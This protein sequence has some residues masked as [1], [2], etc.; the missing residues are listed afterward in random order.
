MPALS[1]KEGTHVV[2]WE[3]NQKSNKDGSKILQ[4]RNCRQGRNIF[5]SEYLILK[6]NTFVTT[7][8]ACK[9]ECNDFNAKLPP[10]NTSWNVLQ[11]YLTY[12][13]DS[14]SPSTW[15]LSEWFVRTWES[16]SL[17]HTPSFLYLYVIQLKLFPWSCWS[18]VWDVKVTH[19]NTIIWLSLPPKKT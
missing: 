15:W 14:D 13:L 12:L 19:H 5:H 4:T 9:V 10:G 3:K 6:H 7:H 8:T 18:W 1:F 16:T 2:N 11:A 17:Q